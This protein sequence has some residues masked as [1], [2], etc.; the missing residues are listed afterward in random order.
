MWQ[1]L[2]DYGLMFLVGAWP[3]GPLGGFVA[4]LILAGAGLAISF[5]L[6]ICLGLAR[7][8]SV[9]VLRWPATAWVYAFRG[10]P[11]IMIIFWAYFVLPVL[12][13]ATV[14][15]FTTA[16]CAIV[17]YESAFLGEIVRA[18]LEGL[19]PGQTEAARAVGLNYAKSMRHV[20]LPQALANM[21]P[22]L[23][24][25]FVSTIKATSI[26]YVIGVQEVTFAAQQVN[27][28]ETAY[29][30][31]TFLVLAALYFVPCFTLSRLAGRL[32]RGL[33]RKRLRA[34]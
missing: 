32:E 29:T 5:P 22:S 16:L 23:V 4:T 19:P 20:I 34:A 13:G 33:A 24:N 27:S 28:M 25:Q 15:A 9:R 10:V 30:L 8:S 7:T 3:R 18:G 2:H 26:V 1:I 14:P 12:T 11:L 17:L 21:I 6:A 31:Q